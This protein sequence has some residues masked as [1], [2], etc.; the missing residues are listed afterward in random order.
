ML[1]KE[2]A[3]RRSECVVL[4]TEGGGEEARK[5]NRTVSGHFKR[6]MEN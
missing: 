2:D 6:F 1:S 3:K 5:R 4:G